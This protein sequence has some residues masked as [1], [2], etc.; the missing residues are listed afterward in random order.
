MAADGRSSASHLI[1]VLA[2]RGGTQL[3]FSLVP[4]SYI[5]WPE[6]GVI[7][8]R[9]CWR[10]LKQLSGIQ[11]LLSQRPFLAQATL[12]RRLQWLILQPVI[13]HS[14]QVTEAEA[15][16]LQCRL[17]S[18]V[19]L[20]DQLATPIQLIAGVDVA[21]DPDTE[22]CFSAVAVCDARTLQPVETRTAMGKVSFGYVPGL[23]SFREI[24]A[25]MLAMGKM[26]SQP[27][28]VIVDGH[29]IAH[30]RR[31][32]IA[33]H[34]GVLYDVP[35]IGC[36]KTHLIG[37]A[38]DPGVRRGARSELQDQGQVVGAVLRTQDGVK[39]VYVS[40]GHRI[41]LKTACEWILR[42]SRKYRLPEP[43]RE[44]NRL[45]NEFRAKHL[46]RQSRL[47]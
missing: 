19:A 42:T 39:P 29:G 6:P 13:S 5:G 46:G 12:P 1:P 31:F 47:K 16:E 38:L 15:I 20:V 28:L 41:S 7:T 27:D 24:P 45:V 43:I 40:Q 35:T 36:A 2:A 11:G 10:R 37:S 25:I 21:Y 17:A 18:Q 26:K 14:F 23:F 30:P 8:A 4:T 22:E 9:L 44:A 32:G 34:L 3:K 33:S